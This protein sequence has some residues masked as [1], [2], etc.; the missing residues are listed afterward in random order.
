MAK[1]RDAAVWV[2]VDDVPG[3]LSRVHQS[4]LVMAGPKSRPLLV[5]LA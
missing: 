4:S 2:L 1:S 5:R 3:A